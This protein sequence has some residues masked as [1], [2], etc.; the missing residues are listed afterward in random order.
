MRHLK[1]S[2]IGLLTFSCG[3][4][5][6]GC[7]GSF[8]TN[9]SA[10]GTLT[11]SS[12]TVNFGQVAVGKT[13]SSVITL[14]NKGSAAVAISELNLT[15][16]P[17]SVSGGGSMPMTVGANASVTVT[18]QFDPTAS[19]S[20]SGELT[21]ASNASN[22]SS[23]SVALSGVGVPMLTELTCVNGS[24][25]GSAS[26]TCTVTLNAAAASGGLAVSLTSNASAVAVPATVTVPAGATSAQFSA[27]AAAVG[28]P[29][30]AM[31]TASAGGVAQ[32]FS[33]QLDAATAILGISASSVSF[34]S[35]SVGS[36][37]THSADSFVNGHHAGDGELGVAHGDGLFDP[38]RGS[39]CD[40][41]SGPNTHP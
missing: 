24:I 7:S 12:G 9:N 2:F 5:L 4:F 20:T 8:V 13:A 39:A 29:E 18:I 22:G 16:Q 21:I 3:L 34:G 38:R 6:G 27:S 41:H 19:G 35:V 32:T 10:A 11:V 28:T 23:T 1:L 14:T 17:F 25:T 26:D 37:A 36:A 33:V 15:G 40:A 31:L 30:A